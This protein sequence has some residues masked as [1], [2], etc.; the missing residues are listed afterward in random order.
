MS[1]PESGGWTWSILAVEAVFPD[2]TEAG[3][4][5]SD[6][7]EIMIFE[8]MICHI[9]HNKYVLCEECD[10]SV[11]FYDFISLSTE[12][13]RRTIVNLKKKVNLFY[14]I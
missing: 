8:T 10:F 11:F 12:K 7:L 13:K 4:S 2:W 3:R 5:S 14:V 9:S 1:P 6:M